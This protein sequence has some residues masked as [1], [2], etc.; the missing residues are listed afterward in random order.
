MGIGLN[1]FLIVVLIV[2]TAFFVAT[3]FAIIRIRS[4]RVDQ[5]VLEGRKDALAVQRVIS[6]LDGYLSACQLGITITALGLG[7][8]GE[9]TVEKMLLP[10]FEHWHFNSELSHVLSFFIAFLSVTYIHVVIGEL[11]PKT[12]AIQKAEFITFL[13]ARPIIIFHKVMYPFI[14]LLNGSANKLIRLFGLKPAK[15][16][17]EAHSE[18]EIQIILSESLQSGKINNTEYGYVSRIFAFDEMVAREIMV[19]R[20]D[21]ICLYTEKSLAEN[22][23]IIR[24]EQYTRFPVVKDNKDHV[25]GMINTKQL[26]LEYQDNSDFDFSKLIHPVLTVPDALPVKSLLKRM[27]QERVHIAILVDEYGGTSGLITI[28]DI[29]EEIVGEIRDEFDADERKDVEKLDDNCY[30]LDGKVSLDDVGALTG[31]DLTNE[32]AETV[33]GWLYS[34]ITDAKVGKSFI[35]DNATFIIREAGKH[36]I[37]K[38]ELI[39]EQEEKR[40]DEDTRSA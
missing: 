28:E 23:A 5:L 29:L 31:I 24:K 34:Q 36:R 26:F 37:K 30:L 40:S 2:L 10:L 8:L 14:W 3:E 25:V 35:R 19:P 1:L 22:M 38:V 11:A 7:W 13:V 16:H 33:G 6:N 12:W 20:T 9:P 32:E 39:I 21:M 27:Q 15:E 4:S 17:E 18:E